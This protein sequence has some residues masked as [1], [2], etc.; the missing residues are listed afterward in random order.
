MVSKAKLY[1]KLDSL[2]LQLE[3][4]LVPHL[5]LAANDQ[6]DFVFCVQA[7]NS[8]RNFKNKNDKKTEELIAIGAQILALREKLGEPSTGTIAERICW[9]CRQWVKLYSPQGK[10]AA[11]LAKQFLQEIEQP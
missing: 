6:N 2:E 8:C 1:L 3:S 11:V 10:T 9:Y 7:F 5:R 4:A